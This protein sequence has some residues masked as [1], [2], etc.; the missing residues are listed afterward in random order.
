MPG[1][2]TRVFALAIA[3]TLAV[4]ASS[5]SGPGERL[6]VE[7]TGTGGAAKESI[8]SRQ[9]GN[10]VPALS[11]TG[12]ATRVITTAGLAD[13]HICTV[14]PVTPLSD[15]RGILESGACGVGTVERR[16]VVTSDPD[17]ADVNV[18]RIP[19]LM[20]GFY[21]AAVQEPGFKN[22]QRDNIEICVG[23]HLDVNVRMEFGE[24]AEPLLLWK[25]LR[26]N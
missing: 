15:P 25:W 11:A 18:I 16:I 2:G 5:L 7:V 13:V 10:W 6:R 12:S 8:Q 24:V 9:A 1:A 26:R 21:R 4:S 14:Q 17:V 19:L 20:P 23:D 22:F 3:S